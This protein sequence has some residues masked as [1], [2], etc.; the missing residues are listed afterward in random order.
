MGL[1]TKQEDVVRIL[2]RV[3]SK[4]GKAIKSPATLA[5]TKVVLPHIPIPGAA[6]AAAVIKVEAAE[7]EFKEPKSG[8]K[9][10]AWAEHQTAKEL[11]RLGLDEKRLGALIEI[12]LLFLKAEARV[13]EPEAEESP[14]PKNRRKA[15]KGDDDEE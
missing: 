10:R 15:K 6:L 13:E 4:V 2:K 1:L 14:K 12:A 3:F 8:A 5:A 7:K 9:K 11:R